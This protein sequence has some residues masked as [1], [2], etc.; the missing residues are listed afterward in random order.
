MRKTSASGQPK[1]R[2]RQVR[3]ASWSAGSFRKRKNAIAPCTA[4]S[5][6]SFPRPDTTQGI[7]SCLRQASIV[8]SWR[9]VRQST[10]RSENGRAF[11]VRFP[12]AAWAESISS[13]PAMRAI[14]P[15]IHMPSASGVSAC[16]R[17][18]AT[19][20]GR[21]GTSVRGAPGLREMTCSAPA[22]I[23]GVER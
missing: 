18:T 5:A 8:S 11:S 16:I 14:S 13:P 20:S 4:S 22:M 7:S 17:R 19:P 15:A 10:A 2:R 6:S 3:S 1:A 12:A 9:C 23:C 21:M